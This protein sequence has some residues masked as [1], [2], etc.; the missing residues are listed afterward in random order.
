MWALKR[1]W[2][3]AYTSLEHYAD[4]QFHLLV[5]DIAP[6]TSDREEVAKP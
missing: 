6:T 2:L 1:W 5:G 3:G 4:E